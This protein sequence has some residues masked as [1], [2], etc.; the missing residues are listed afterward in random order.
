MSTAA[1]F[2]LAWPDLIRAA[3]LLLAGAV[4]ARLLQHLI[5][6]TPL[7]NGASLPVRI[8]RSTAGWVVFSLF[9][10]AALHQL[11]FK[12]S[13]LLGAA[14]IFSVALGF[15]SQT[16]AT[17]LVSGLFLLGERSFEVG[18]TIQVGTTVGE[19]LSVDLLSVK[20]RTFDNRYVRL[21]NETLIKSELVNLSKFPIRRF[22]MLLGIA[23]RTDIALARAILLRVAE[24]NPLC[25]EEPKPLIILQG[26]GAS[27]IDL[28]FSVWAARGNYLEMK[29]TMQEQVKMA[30]DAEGIEIPFPQ[31]TLSIAPDTVSLPIHMTERNRDE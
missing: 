6:R 26:F 10:I 22:D 18:D 16:S 14:G 7:A 3:L 30:F 9:A 8:I 19:I 27:S 25:L 1:D 15:A 12:L 5:N 21:P 24:A 20:L 2:A 29:N 31:T 4:L 23:Y 11:G 13:V 28:Q 17:N